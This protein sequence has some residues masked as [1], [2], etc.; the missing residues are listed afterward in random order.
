M[1]SSYGVNYRVSIFGESHSAAIGVV[2]EGLPA[3]SAI[4]MES[5]HAFMERRAPGRDAL[6]TARR[7]ADVPEF[8]C[9]VKNYV[10]TGAP[11]SAII[12]NLFS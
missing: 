2:I 11:I 3:G 1:S 5:L 4:D 12:R 10:A 9:G 7:E 6:S 8:L